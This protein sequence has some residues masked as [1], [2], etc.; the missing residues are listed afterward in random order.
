[1]AAT[2]RTVD[3]RPARRRSIEQQ[4]ARTGEERVELV[5]GDDPVEAQHDP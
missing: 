4:P 1:V 5:L 2:E 3:H